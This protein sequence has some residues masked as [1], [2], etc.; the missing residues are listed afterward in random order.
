MNNNLYDSREMFYGATPE[1]FRKAEMLRENMTT[2]EK[3]LWEI[4]KRGIDGYKFRRQHPIDIFIA[5]FYCHKARLVIEIDGDIHNI[6]EIHEYDEGRTDELENYGIKVIR[7]KNQ[8]VNDNIEQVIET[9][10]IHL[11]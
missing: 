9:I 3:A 7:F 4:L 11:C 6:G 8:E 1:I 10:K 2:S 5:D